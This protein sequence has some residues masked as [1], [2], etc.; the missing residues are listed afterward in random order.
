MTI[1]TQ[2]L[3]FVAGSA[4]HFMSFNPVARLLHGMN[5]LITVLFNKLTE[6]C[7]CGKLPE[8]WIHRTRWH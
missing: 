1:A 7:R 6:W 8:L 4:A 5:L 3:R 2:F